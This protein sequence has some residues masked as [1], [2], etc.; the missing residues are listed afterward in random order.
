M[1]YLSSCAFRPFLYNLD[2]SFDVWEFGLVFYLSS[3]LAFLFAP[4]D[5]ESLLSLV[6]T[7]AFNYDLVYFLWSMKII[8]MV[9]ALV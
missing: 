5:L 4:L 3:P 8:V 9:L 1:V 2:Y 6:E 7:V